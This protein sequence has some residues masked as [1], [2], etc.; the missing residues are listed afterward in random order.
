MR[1]FDC[2]RHELLSLSWFSCW[3]DAMFVHSLS[4]RNETNVCIVFL[5]CFGFFFLAQD[6]VNVVGGVGVLLPLLEQVCEAELVY[7]G[8]QEISD[9]LGP[10]LTSSRG[11]AAMLLP[12]NKS[13]G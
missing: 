11:R 9:L 10:E 7:N 4:D 8:S 13:A 5:F 3:V 6:V 12:L 1:Y 2:V